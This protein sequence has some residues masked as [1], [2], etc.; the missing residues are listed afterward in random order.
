VT[1]VEERRISVN[2]RAPEEWHRRL[3]IAAARRGVT[4]SELVRQLVE[5]FLDR[6]EGDGMNDRPRQ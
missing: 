2:V 4:I 3:K 5:E 6:E 1:Q